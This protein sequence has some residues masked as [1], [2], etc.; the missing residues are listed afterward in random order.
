LRWIDSPFPDKNGRPVQLAVDF[1]LEAR[2]GKTV[3]RLVHSG[4]D[5][6]ADWDEQIEGLES[7]WTYFLRQLKHYLE[8]HRGE[9]RDMVW[10]RPKTEDG[11]AVW[12]KL[13][14]E[15]GLGSVDPRRLS[16]GSRLSLGFGGKK[17]LEAEVEIA[18]VPRSFSAVI[19]QLNDAVLFVE[20]EGGGGR[21]GI[22]LSTYG[23]PATQL[24][25]LQSQ[26]DWMVSALFG[27]ETGE[28][29]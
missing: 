1:F 22:W 7:G 23:L 27:Q 3:V 21:C 6:S 26:L 15:K 12:G 19:P 17:D 2:G 4:F 16:T 10:A 20:L 25:G 13:F 9:R 11:P 24:S 14:S 5:A 8:R 18:N 28:G 29:R